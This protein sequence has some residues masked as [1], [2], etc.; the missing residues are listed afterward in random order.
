M[1]RE[2]PAIAADLA[3][4]LIGSLTLDFAFVRLGDPTA[5]QAVEVTRGDG[6]KGFPPWL[7]ER[8]V[9]FGQNLSNG[10]RDQCWRVREI[11]LRDR[12]SYW[13]KQR[14]GSHC[15]G[16]WSLRFSRPDR[17]ATAFRSGE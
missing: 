9:R 8:L 15:D 3:D 7:Q 4:L 6:W 12:N 10:N 16:V 14:A 17:S 13:S 1:G 11:L 2:P 5:N